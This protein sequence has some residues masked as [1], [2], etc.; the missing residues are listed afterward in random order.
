MEQET[1]QG[2]QMQGE[3]NTTATPTPTPVA[4]N[5]AVADHKL[6]AILLSASNAWREMP[7][8]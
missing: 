7:L 1:N 3:Q 4:P 8:L 6:F 5:S 2:P